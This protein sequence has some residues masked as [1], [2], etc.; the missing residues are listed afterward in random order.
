MFKR[1]LT[2]IGLALALSA[3]IGAQGVPRCFPC[4]PDGTQK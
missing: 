3:T 4:N 1:I 2:L